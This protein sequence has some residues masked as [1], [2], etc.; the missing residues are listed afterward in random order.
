[1]NIGKMSKSAAL[2]LTSLVV[3][4]VV[5]LIQI[6]DGILRFVVIGL[7]FVIVFLSFVFVLT[8]D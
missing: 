3:I 2:V 1:M 7:G 5:V 6:S 4:L 8:R